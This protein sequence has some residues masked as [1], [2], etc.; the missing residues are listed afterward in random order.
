MAG[1]RRY[2]TIM[3]VYAKWSVVSSQSNV[4]VPTDQNVL[5]P[6]TLAHIQTPESRER[7]GE[8]ANGGRTKS[9]RSFQGASRLG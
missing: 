7:E 6:L 2:V 3:K 9:R 8:A 4:A 5:H 1:T